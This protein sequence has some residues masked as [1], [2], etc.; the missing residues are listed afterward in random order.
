MIINPVHSH[1]PPT[2]RIDLSYEENYQN[3]PFI[4]G[5]FSDRKAGGFKQFMGFEVRSRFGVPAGPLLNSRWI[6][7]YAKLG[8]DLLVYK[9]VRTEAHPSHPAPNCMIL[10]LSGQLEEKD[11]GYTLVAN[12]EISED[13]N[14]SH[15]SITNSF[16]MPSRDP[17]VWQEDVLKAKSFLNPG[18][19]LIVSVVGTPRKGQDLADDYARGAMMAKEAGADVV[20]INLSCPNV[21]TGE[22]SL[23]T[24]PE[25]SSRVTR[26]VQRALHGT[27]LIIK[28]G[29][30]SDFKILEKVIIA[31]A[32][33]T[34]GISSINTLSFKVVKPDGSQALPGPGRLQSGVCGDAIRSCGLHQSKRIADIRRRHRLDFALIG[35]G[36]IMTVNDIIAYEEAGT[37]AS[38]SATGAMWD[39]Y[40]ALK[41]D[42][43]RLVRN[44]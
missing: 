10:N 3:G 26:K 23:F 16:G 20:E 14:S 4:D 5:E 28:M 17:K 32:R 1:I 25:A 39:P 44:R 13:K 8:F 38:M 2:Y 41:Y 7:V 18:Q 6:Q 34:E 31:N 29:Y 19:I 35:V 12:E 36:G 33:F 37:D 11:F 42:Q 15:V 9:T 21:T 22:G 43:F 24:D 27:P 30:I 40:L